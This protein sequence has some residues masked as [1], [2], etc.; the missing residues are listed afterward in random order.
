M[1]DIQDLIENAPADLDLDWDV[2]VFDDREAGLD[3]DPDALSINILISTTMQ[4]TARE[5]A[6]LLKRTRGGLGFHPEVKRRLELEQA[7]AKRRKTKKK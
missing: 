1:A 4:V 6:R 5:A 7:V 3:P 2:M